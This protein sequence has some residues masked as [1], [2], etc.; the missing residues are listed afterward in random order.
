MWSLPTAV[1]NATGCDKNGDVWPMFCYIIEIHVVYDRHQIVRDLC[2]MCY[3]SV[4]H[5]G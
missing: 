1:P 2:Q 4:S 3:F 5:L